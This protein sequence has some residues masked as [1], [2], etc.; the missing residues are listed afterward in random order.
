MVE[1]VGVERLVFANDN[2]L[3]L[4]SLVVLELELKLVVGWDFLVVVVVVAFVDV[5]HLGL[6][7]N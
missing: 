2:L 1:F 6:E 5:E 3:E 7:D 4:V